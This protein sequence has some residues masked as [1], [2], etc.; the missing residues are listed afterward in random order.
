M[1]IPDDLNTRLASAPVSLDLTREEHEHG[2][3]FL[4]RKIDQLRWRRLVDNVPHEIARRNPAEFG[5]WSGVGVDDL[6]RVG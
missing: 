4:L 1:K 6:E 3:N 5:D 2:E